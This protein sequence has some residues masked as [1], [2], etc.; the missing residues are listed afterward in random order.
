MA[1][2]EKMEKMLWK[3]KCRVDHLTKMLPSRSFRHE[4]E[5]KQFRYQLRLLV[6]ELEEIV[7]NGKDRPVRTA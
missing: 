6:G 5:A 4:L 7:S 3:A 2:Q 1:N